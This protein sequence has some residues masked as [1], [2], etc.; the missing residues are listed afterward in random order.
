MKKIIEYAM[1]VVE[2]CESC[3]PMGGNYNDKKAV[4]YVFLLS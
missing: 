4:H 2:E 3:M 1:L